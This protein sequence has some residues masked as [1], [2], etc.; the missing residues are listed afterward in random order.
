MPA[1]N[2]PSVIPRAS[3]HV[4]QTQTLPLLLRTFFTIISM[5]NQNKTVIILGGGS[6]GLV[7]VAMVLVYSNP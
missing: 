5:M 4:P 1:I 7:A 3:I 6:G 2:S